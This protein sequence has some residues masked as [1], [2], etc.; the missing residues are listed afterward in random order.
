M[1]ASPDD[2]DA[3]VELLSPLV[4]GLYSSLD[5]ARDLARAHFEQHDMIGDEYG[6]GVHH[7]ARAHTRRLL[8]AAHA[9]GAIAPWQ[10]NAP[11]PNLQIVLRHEQLTLRVLRPAGFDVPPPGP[12]TARRAYYSNLHDNLLGLQGSKLLALW[13]IDSQE[14]EIV[15]R[16]VR[17]RGVWRFGASAKLD[18]DLAL[19]RRAGELARLEFVPVDDLEV[20]LPFEEDGDVDGRAEDGRGH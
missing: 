5:R 14:D 19:P 10:L 12:N 9:S 18:I 2:K 11:G 17:P 3:L 20:K 7:L 1:A 13:S 6:S 16:V 4:D 15:V 8:D